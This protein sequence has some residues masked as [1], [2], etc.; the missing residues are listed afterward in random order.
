MKM[1]T[2]YTTL[3]NTALAA[4]IAL[5]GL[6]ACTSRPSAVEQRKAEKRQED[7]LALIAQEKTYHYFDSLYQSLLPSLDTLLPRFAYEEKT[8]YED[9]GH[10]VHR[11]LR[12]TSNTHRNYIQTYVRDDGK[13]IVRFYY[14]DT[15]RLGFE[16]VRFEVEGMEN[17]FE[18]KTHAFEAEGWHEMMTIEGEKALECLH[19]VDAYSDKRIRVT[20]EGSR[21]R[22]VYYLSDNDKKALVA[23]YGLGMAM[24]DV[25]ELEERMKNTDRE[26]KK[27]QNRLS[28]QARNTTEE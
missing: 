2:F 22:A 10:Y 19:F 24:K 11:I 14:S 4:T 21:S 7:S 26:I 12:T 1:N 17:R 28:K 15:K 18:G 20:L 9:H 27:Y 25:K 5:S 3:K 16:A 8:E 13:T 23:T 6:S